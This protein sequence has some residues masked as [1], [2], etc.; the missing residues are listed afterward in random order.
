MGKKKLKKNTEQTIIDL[1]QQPEKDN[2]PDDT[3]GIGSNVQQIGATLAAVL[4]GEIVEAATAQL[5][6]KFTQPS[7]SVTHGPKDHPNL[8]E[9]KS[10]LAENA[11]LNL[12]GHLKDVAPTVTD[13]VSFARSAMAAA[14]PDMD[15]IVAVLKD[16]G[17]RL[18]QKSMDALESSPNSPGDLL[19]S[20]MSNTSNAI[21]GLNSKTTSTLENLDKGSKKGKRKKKRKNKK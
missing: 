8:R 1:P 17:Q 5:V 14:A 18:K 3:N 19:A 7:N 9:D 15:D 13:G 6:Q 21:S 16:V 4:I 10:H 2:A 11:K 20:I 12:E